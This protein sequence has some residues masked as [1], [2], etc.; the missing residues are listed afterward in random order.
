[1][2]VATDDK[3]V[4]VPRSGVHESGLRVTRLPARRDLDN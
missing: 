2:A 3:D 4:R 1:M